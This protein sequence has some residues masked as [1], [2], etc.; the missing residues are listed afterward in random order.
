MKVLEMSVEIAHYDMQQLQVQN[1]NFPAELQVREEDYM[2]LVT[3]NLPVSSEG[4]IHSTLMCDVENV[5][6][7]LPSLKNCFLEKGTFQVPAVPKCGGNLETK[8]FKS[9]LEQFELVAS[10]V[11]RKTFDIT[12][13]V[14][15]HSKFC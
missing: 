5:S 14:S 15:I 6:G 11:P 1:N 13:S 2:V 7:V 9:C 10:V 8:P 3:A 12:A 4:T